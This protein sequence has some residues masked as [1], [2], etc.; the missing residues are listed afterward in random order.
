MTL[1]ATTSR[2]LTLLAP[3]IFVLLWSTGFIGAK[4]GM[5]HAEPFTFLGVRF[6]LASAIFFAL[7]ILTW[8]LRMALRRGV[9]T[10]S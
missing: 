5:P 2:Y 10:W 7:L 3:I 9:V 6:T 1:S 8:P 4:M